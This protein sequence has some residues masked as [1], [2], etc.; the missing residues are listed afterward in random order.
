MIWGLIWTLILVGLFTAVLTSVRE[1]PKPEIVIETCS[2][3]AALLL[4]IVDRVSSRASARRGLLDGVIDELTAN[5]HKLALDIWRK[6]ESVL[7]TEA[8]DT[9]N[10]LR[11]YYPHLSVSALSAAVLST[12]FD[13]HDFTLI[14]KLHQW[15]SS[16]EECNARLVMGQLLLF[17]LSAD[18]AGMQERLSLHLSI[19]ALPIALAKDALRKLSSYLLEYQRELPLTPEGVASLEEIQNLI[20]SEVDEVPR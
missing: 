10:G 19:C 17:F 3:L 9:R 14:R 15:E 13:S 20:G 16:A 5:A 4:V 12:Q 18:E 11:F 6:D 7:R 1:H 8:A 2:L